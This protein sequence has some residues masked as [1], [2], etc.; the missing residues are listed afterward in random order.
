MDRAY[1]KVVVFALFLC[2]YA[3]TSAETID[4]TVSRSDLGRHLKNAELLLCQ[5]SPFREYFT[6]TSISYAQPNFELINHHWLADIV[7]FLAWRVGDFE[8]LNAVLHSAR[9]LAFGL[10]YLI[11]QRAAGLPLAVTL[12]VCLMPSVRARASVRPEIFTLIT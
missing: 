1:T 10:V 9:A 12:A 4:L 8:G 3:L 7:F 11:A 2:L 6:P 5:S